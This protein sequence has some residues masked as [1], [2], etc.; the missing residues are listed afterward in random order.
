LKRGIVPPLTALPPSPRLWRD[1]QAPCSL[2]FY[3]ER[4]GKAKG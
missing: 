3:R 4:R 2:T 1:K